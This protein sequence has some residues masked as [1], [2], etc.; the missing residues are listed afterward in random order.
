MRVIKKQIS[1]E[2]FT[3]RLPGVVP[4]YRER[5][6]KLYFF[7]EESLKARE[8]AFP[9][10]YGL[11]PMSVKI[12]DKCLSWETISD[13]YYFFVEYYH[14]LKDSRRCRAEV[15]TSATDYYIHESKNGYADQMKYGVSRYIYQA[16]D[17]VYKE[18]EFAKD[19]IFKCIP[20]MDIPKEYVDYWHTTK[21][22]YPD[23]IK[24]K[25]WFMD[26]YAKYK[27]YTG[28]NECSN[29]TDCCDCTEYFNRG[30]NDMYGKLVTK[31]FPIPK[32]VCEPYMGMPISLLVSIDDMGEFSIFSEEYEVGKDYRGCEY[33]NTDNTRKGT[34][35]SISGDAMTLTSG[36]GFKFDTT[37]QEKEYDPTNWTAHKGDKTVEIEVNVCGSCGYESMD[38][39]L[40]CPKCGSTTPSSKRVKIPEEDVETRAYQSTSFEYGKYYGFRDDFKK[41]TGD[42]PDIVRSKL[43]RNYP[44]SPLSSV[45]IN[46]SL[47]LVSTD[48]YGYYKGDTGKTYYVQRELYTDTPYTFING[49]KIY[50]D[51]NQMKDEPYQSI[52]KYFYFPF[53]YNSTKDTENECG[54]NMKV[55]QYKWFPR[56]KSKVPGDL[57]NHFRYGE[58]S[59]EI[60]GTSITINGTVYQ[61]VAGSFVNYDNETFYVGK[62]NKV[63]EID[64]YGDLVETTEYTYD[65]NT[66]IASSTYNYTAD[67][68]EFGKV[69]GK[70]HSRFTD[71]RSTSGWLVDDIGEP[72]EGKYNYHNYSGETN[73]Q[74]P[75]GEILDL[76]FEQGNTVNIRP[77]DR[78]EDEEG[79]IYFGD[80]LTKMTFYCKKNDG[81][82]L[83]KTVG[84]EEVIDK[85]DWNVSSLHT[86]LSFAGDDIDMSVMYCDVEYVKGG[87]FRGTVEMKPVG[88]DYL[89]FCTV[90]TRIHPE[91]GVTYTET[92][93]FIMTEVQYNLSAAKS[94]SLPSEKDKPSSH[95]L[96][97]PVVC[98]LLEQDKQE[99]NSDYGIYQYPVANFTMQLPSDNTGWFTPYKNETQLY[100]VFREEYRF[101]NSIME[102]VDTN[103]NIDRGTNAA[104]EKHLK[105]GEVTSMEALEQFG[106]GYFK[107]SDI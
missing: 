87:I 24:W 101:G 14:L 61:W 22:Y 23:F 32:E 84:E 10:N 75:E 18:R 34:V 96:S 5:D 91:I 9:S 97:Y 105:L 92:V 43:T 68:Y 37:Y 29:A 54:D 40:K 3:S 27:S 60:E 74:P 58:N 88:D 102:K 106:N 55:P 81:S 62:D 17:D 15:Y 100:P 1:L 70:S 12:G 86:I 4:A 2:N 41:E 52:N 90:Y 99:I 83:T 64:E 104:L 59:Y 76:V 51:V 78:F 98:Y 45:Y 82:F 53:F 49:K 42:T 93:R 39:F 69:T 85:R 16:L 50:A 7:D 79:D 25:G 44:V 71:F 28:I 19:T 94:D 26:R 30:G 38:V 33:G 95:N 107:I 56:T 103:V 21:L 6:G 11:V 77:D 36:T 31:V 67:V 8:Y 66:K 48:E 73:Q 63:Y 89:V 35:V 20:S 57:R 47:C 13:W 46:G 80:M 65:A 72:I